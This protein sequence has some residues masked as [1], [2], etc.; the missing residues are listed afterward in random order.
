MILLLSGAEKALIEAAH[1][2]GSSIMHQARIAAGEE[3][4]HALKAI[5]KDHELDYRSLELQ[6]DDVGYP[7]GVVDKSAKNTNGSQSPINKGIEGAVK[8]KQ[9]SGAQA[10]GWKPA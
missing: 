3:I 4:E 1:K 7:I 2:L 5:A 10:N 9:K 8:N 6:L